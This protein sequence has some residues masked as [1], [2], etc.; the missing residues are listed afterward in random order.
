[1]ALRAFRTV[2]PEISEFEA[3]QARW[4]EISAARRALRDKLDGCKAALA[5]ADHRPGPGEHFSPLLEERALR[6]LAG[7]QPNRDRLIRE[8]AELEDEQA[9]QAATYS[10]ESVAWKLALEN[11][12]RRRAEALRPRHR[13]A[14]KKIAQL[15]EQLSLAVEAERAVRAELAEVGGNGALPDAGREFGSLHEYNSALGSWNRRMVAE[16]AL[17]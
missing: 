6:Y 11:E 8:V 2:T 12:T 15:V 17:D 14:V 7:R 1:M 4:A 16:G 9:Q 13:A 10:V 3:A 5:F